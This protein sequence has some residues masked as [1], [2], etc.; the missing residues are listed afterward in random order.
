MHDNDGTY[1]ANITMEGEHS[2]HEEET[3]RIKLFPHP[4]NKLLALS[5]VSE[6]PFREMWMRKGLQTFEPL[7]QLETA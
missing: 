1:L 4:F 2:E 6:T 3:G 5:E 7:I